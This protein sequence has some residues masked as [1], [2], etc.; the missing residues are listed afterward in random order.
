MKPMTEKKIYLP[1]LCKEIQTKYGS[2][3]KINV[4]VSSLLNIVAEHAENGWITFAVMKRREVGEKGQT[5][6][7]FVDKWRK[8]QPGEQSPASA[9][10]RPVQSEPESDSGADDVP[11]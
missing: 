10:S 11:F 1:G 6:C 3:I 5:H 2:L 8:P 7:I 4:P 9:P